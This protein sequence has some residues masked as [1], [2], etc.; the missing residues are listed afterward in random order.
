MSKN[1]TRMQAP[2]NGRRDIKAGYDTFNTYGH[3]NP[4]PDPHM[5]LT[6]W[7][8]YQDTRVPHEDIDNDDLRKQTNRERHHS[9][10][11]L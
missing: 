9:Y 2:K 1:N 3:N 10:N 11:K 4:K 8:P 5:P 6:S 7:E